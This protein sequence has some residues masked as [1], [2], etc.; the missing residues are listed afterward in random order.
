MKN[1][2]TTILI[3]LLA[4]STLLWVATFGVILYLVWRMRKVI[5]GISL[6]IRG[7]SQLGKQITELSKSIGEAK[8]RFEKR[9]G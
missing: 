4:L 8:S 5:L 1:E 3:V 6:A 9:A 7:I 2:L